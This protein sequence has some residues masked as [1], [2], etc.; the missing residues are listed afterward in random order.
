MKI[1]LEATSIL[2]TIFLISTLDKIIKSKKKFEIDVLFLNNHINDGSIKQIKFLFSESKYSPK[3]FDCRNK[4]K[5]E[6][7]LKNK[8]H[9]DYLIV[10]SRIDIKAHNTNYIMREF[11]IKTAN[12]DNVKIV[13]DK[14]NYRNLLSVDDGL[15]NWKYVNLNF[16][17]KYIPHFYIDKNKTK[18]LA[19]INK[20]FYKANYSQIVHHY[21]LFSSAD[22]TNILDTFKKNLKKLS[23][24]F[25]NQ[26][27]IKYLFVGTWPAF[28]N[29]LSKKNKDIQLET[30]MK[31]LK[32]NKLPHDK[33]Y[34][35]HH[36]K[37]RL[38]L[39]YD[40]KIKFINLSKK[41][42]EAPIEVMINSLPNLKEIY[43]FPSTS[44]FLINYLNL[45]KVKI[46][47]FI[48]KNSMIYAS[49]LEN[50]FENKNFNLIYV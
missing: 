36:P 35:K 1:C 2:Q 44:L 22:E 32:N 21:S 45:N 8:I 17:E 50:I 14:L 16:Y 48:K 10:R 27:N 13:L 29:R 20:Y 5:L 47:I 49:Q 24:N 38:K 41:L 18:K 30:L 37:F 25:K 12:N 34:L 28:K 46:N 9:Y 31:F 7:V 26:N 40:K 6:Y 19:Y 23:K 4:N 42:N 33:I 11:F 43:A 39:V 15:S 3:Y